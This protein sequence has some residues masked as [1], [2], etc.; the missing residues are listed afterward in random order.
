[1]VESGL[2]V[3]SKST[4]FI[5]RYFNQLSTTRCF[6]NVSAT[7]ANMVESAAN[8]I[9]KSTDF[10]R[11]ISTIP[12]PFLVERSTLIQREIAIWACSLIQ[13]SSRV[14]V[15]PYSSSVCCERHTGTASGMTDV[16]SLS[17]VAMKY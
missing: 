14:L 5:R 8:V 7:Y 12:L 1:M 11:Y 6:F 9:S 10:Q 15:S 13:Y 16:L 3:I 2:N 17:C 4:S